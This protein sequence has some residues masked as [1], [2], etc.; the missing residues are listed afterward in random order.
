MLEPQGDAWRYAVVAG[1]SYLLGLAIG[2]LFA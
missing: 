2:I 1:A